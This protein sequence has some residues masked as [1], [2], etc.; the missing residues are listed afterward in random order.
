MDM[1]NPCVSASSAQSVFHPLTPAHTKR[2]RHRTPGAPAS[3]FSA[4]RRSC[5]APGILHLISTT[6]VV[7]NS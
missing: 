6:L 2:L 1:K 5:P 7:T 4:A 3:A